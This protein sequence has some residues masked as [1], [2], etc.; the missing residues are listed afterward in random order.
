MT[1]VEALKLTL[2]KEEA[3]IRL[4]QQLIREHPN[5]KDLL[6]SLLTE[7]QKHKK[8]IEGKISE[9]NRYA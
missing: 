6:Y 8:L 1:I 2:S 7:E 3:S 9:L 5:L 4:Y